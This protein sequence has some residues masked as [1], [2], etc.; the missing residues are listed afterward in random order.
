ML[1]LI[2]AAY[3]STGFL[4]CDPAAL[5]TPSLPPLPL[6]IFACQLAEAS[7]IWVPFPRR[8]QATPTV[9]V[10]RPS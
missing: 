4:I 10:T 8:D 5:Q 6:M 9:F 2:Q 7:G 1:P 3:V